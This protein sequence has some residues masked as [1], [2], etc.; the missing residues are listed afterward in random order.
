MHVTSSTLRLAQN[1]RSQG[2]PLAAPQSQA[3]ADSISFNDAE[4]EEL[5]DWGNR[6]RPELG[7]LRT[8]PAG[9]TDPTLEKAQE[10]LEGLVQQLAGEDLKKQGVQ[11]HLE[12][13]SGNVPQAALDDDMSMEETW[14]EE[15]PGK[16]WPVR[17]WLGEDGNRKPIYRLA[18]NLGM[19][20]ALDSREEIA[21]VLSQQTEQ[22][23]EHDRLDPDNE[24][25][26]SPANQSFIEPR[27]MQGAADRAA[28]ARMAKAGFNPRAALTALEKLYTLNAPDYPEDDLKRGLTAYSH[29]QEHEG[30]RLG[31]VQA[32]VE[33]FVRRQD[34]STSQPLQPIPA[35]L[36]VEAP[37]EYEKPLD[38][39]AAYQ[40]DMK[41]LATSLAG[42]ETPDWMFNEGTKPAEVRR[43]RRAGGSTEDNEQALLAT[44]EH[45]QS[46][47]QLSG[48]NRI[49]GMLRMLLALDSAPTSE[50]FSFS[51][52]T[53]TKLGEFFTNNGREWSADKLFSS[54][55]K[56]EKSLSHD[57]VRDVV[58][59]EVFQAAVGPAL[60]GL[61]EAV[62]SAWITDSKGES[63]LEE[64]PELIKQNQNEKRR[65]WALAGAIDGSTLSYIR[66]LDAKQLAQQ[67]G[68][69]GASEAMTLS[70]DL[71]GLEDLKPR[72][73]EDLK[74]A[75]APIL[76]ASNANREDQARLRLR[77]P[78]SEAQH[79][80]GY[81]QELGKSESWTAFSPE[82]DAQL[83]AMLKD[84][85]L[86]ASRQPDLVFDESRPI[87]YPESIEKRVAGLVDQV[88]PD[89]AG[90]VLDH[91]TRHTEHYKRIPA[92]D[93]SREWLV[94]VARKLAA[95]D[96]RS[97]VDSLTS[98]DLSQHSGLT[99][100]TF[101]EGYR[102]SESDLP[103]N[104]TA[105]LKALDERREADEFKPKRSDYPNYKEYVKALDEYYDRADKMHETIGFVAGV[106]CRLVLG[107]LALLGID[108]ELSADVASRLNLENFQQV[109]QGG[110]AAKERSELLT[111]LTENEETEYVGADAGAFLM[112]GFLNVQDQIEGVGQ[113]HDLAT[114]S[115]DFSEGGLEARVGTRRK[116]GDNLF[117]RLQ[118]MP[119]AEI[120]EWLGKEKVLDL[121]SAAQ[122]S[123]LL[124]QTLGDSCA[125]GADPE[126]LSKMVSELDEEYSLREEYPV[127]F[128]GLRDKIAE[129]A[130]LQ[131]D[132]V[133]AVFPKVEESVTETNS[134]YAKQAR[135]LSALL[136][137]ARERSAQEQIDTVEYLMGRQQ[138]MPNYLESAFESQSFAPLAESLQTTRQDLL[139]ADSQTRVM[140]ANSFLAGPSGIMRTKEGKESVIDHFLKGLKDE[141][142]EL[143]DKIARAVLASHGK[144]DTLAVA[145]ILGQKPEA[146]TE[147]YPQSEDKKGQLDEAS[148]LNR[149]FDA[150][151]VPG[152]KMKQY[153]AFTSEFKDFKDAFESAQDSAMPLNYFQ[154]LKLIQNRF[155]DEWP[156]DL[157]IDRVLGSGSVNVAIRYQNHETGKREVVS[158]G[159][160]DIEETTSYDFERFHKFI[161]ELTRTP[162]D[163]EKFG[164]VLGLLNLIEDSVALEFDKESA[165]NVQKMAK[166][167]YSHKENG[168]TVQSID[169]FQVKNLGL[170]MEEAKGRTARKTFTKEPEV[171]K[172]AMAAMAAAE[173]GVLKGQPTENTLR[174]KPLFA[175]P[176]FHDG[177]VMIDK[178]IKTVTILDFG[179]AVPISNEDR[180]A[181]LDLLT[182]IGKADQP[183]SAARRLNKRYFK[184]D[185]VIKPSDLEEL[186]KRTDRM[187]IFIHLLSTVS[188]K[189]AKVPL[190]SVHWVLGVNRQLALGEK[191]GQPIDKQVRNMVITHKLWLPLGLYNAAHWAKEKSVA[192][193]VGIADRLSGWIFGKDEPPDSSVFKSEVPPAKETEKVKSEYVWRPD[194][195]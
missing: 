193:A 167:T 173:F 176:D 61:I 139:E 54:L 163:K 7:R 49:D 103:D 154:V 79:L 152:I 100:K 151:G 132:T 85:A 158:L 187:D 37:A 44:A 80:N 168:W 174:Q 72:F 92:G 190:S 110:E 64:L 159:R 24:E 78:Y 45:L 143:G 162:E 166:R 185:E 42:A 116:L 160:Q 175:N 118:E 20:R 97:L 13:F 112:D 52:P 94:P 43:L 38:D 155:G 89:D 3:P 180:D 131:P 81:L 9:P 71:L 28:I 17:G 8:P 95:Q 192:L 1:R 178:E 170:F 74:S 117:P 15:H 75:T 104:S 53:L 34:P 145:F 135:A 31:M 67:P 87:R 86:L 177:Q 153:L 184:G 21:F 172:E 26:L 144:A 134:A 66:K 140:V 181:G 40:A 114:R 147:F 65:D 137:M 138:E 6:L 33:E 191:I 91:L 120:R 68:R 105:S 189:G 128:N 30:M 99:R 14:Q 84:F 130:K 141:N 39:P 90:A 69:H 51:Q 83:P 156:K 164:Y 57:M 5:K 11:L 107:R 182:I 82:F 56:H 195:R 2:A 35:E 183:E 23:L 60:P 70:N 63:K 41:N 10:Y 146:E 18:V 36:K 179:Q 4:K 123:D 161:D 133:D 169:A 113:W 108:K 62:P 126:A 102:L 188:R 101:I 55:F 171:Y 16:P 119:A 29:D 96:T 124:L 77:A 93:E 12:V 58:F 98:P 109:L 27:D 32:G 22:L 76:E 165:M 59:N 47:P 121:L 129:Q 150:Y 115:I 148:I 25:L 88:K 111:R 106:E 19:L 157:E 48:Q 46:N 136:A 186:L 142:R 125:P 122:S 149:L 194:F 73:R 127:A 50:D